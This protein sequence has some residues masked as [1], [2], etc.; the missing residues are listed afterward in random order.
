MQH[1]PV[2]ANDALTNYEIAVELPGGG[3]HI[4]W[5]KYPGFHE[6]ITAALAFADRTRGRVISVEPSRDSG[7]RW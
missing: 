6:A 5:Q 3:C 7:M 4:L 2:Q 1:Q